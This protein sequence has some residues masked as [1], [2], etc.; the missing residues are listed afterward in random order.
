MPDG[1]L[2]HAG[3][4]SGSQPASRPSWAVAVPR[5]RLPCRVTVPDRQGSSRHPPRVTQPASAPAP[6]NSPATI[7]RERRSSDPRQP[8]ALSAARLIGA[9]P[10]IS[11]AYDA[12]VQT[13]A[14]PADTEQSDERADADQA[15]RE[16]RQRW[17]EAVR[18][19]PDVTV[20]LQ[21]LALWAEQ[22][23]DGL[24]PLTYALVDEDEQ[25]RARAEA[26]WEQ[27]I[28]QE[29]ELGDRLNGRG[30]G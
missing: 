8:A 4:V 20:R 11:P 27:Q 1:A 5:R 15:Q 2:W 13:A 16:A 18:E 9:S 19:N 10:A 29:E 6:T 30:S 23:G 28:T 21:A 14:S 3:I 25:V 12:R 26:L 22:P 17:F 24:N 7:E